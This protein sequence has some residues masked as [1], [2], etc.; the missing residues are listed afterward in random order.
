METTEIT[1]ELKTILKKDLSST[2]V[3]VSQFVDDLSD[4]SLEA[5]VKETIPE[6]KVTAEESTTIYNFFKSGV[7]ETDMFTKHGISFKKSEKIKDEIAKLKTDANL[8]MNPPA[9]EPEPEILEE[10]IILE[11]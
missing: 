5:K 3:D 11:K 8:I 2:L 4:C 9:P 10:E 1:E 7:G 6:A